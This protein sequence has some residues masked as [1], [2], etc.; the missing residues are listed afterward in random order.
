M[1][2]KWIVAKF[3]GSSVKDAAAMLRSSQI[4]ENNP[5]IKIVVISATQN[6][7][8]QL[9]FVARAAEK[10]DIETLNHVTTELV[11]KHLNIAKELFTSPKVLEELEELCGELK[12]LGSEILEEQAYTPKMMDELY[13]LGERMSSLLV[14][15]LLRLRIPNKTIN[16]LDARKIIKTSS[17]F[18]R[19]EPQI[20]LI[21]KNA[22]TDIIPYLNVDTIFVTQGF[23]GADLLGNTTTLGREGSDYSA[24]LFGEAIDAEL[25][26]IWTDV[27]GVA[28]SDPRIIENAKFIK[29]LSYDEATALATLGAK[30]LFP[31]TLLPTKRKN[32]PVFV[33]SS[34]DPSQGGTLI[35]N[36]Q[37]KGFS[38]K[39]VSQLIRPEG[40]LVSFIGT[41]LDEKENL[42]QILQKDLGENQFQFSDLTAVSISFKVTSPKMDKVESLKIAHDV[43]AKF[44]SLEF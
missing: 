31:T 41:H 35:T 39:G 29:E 37:N 14:S 32:I 44:M 8:N 4:I 24:A 5:K 34:L 33:G 15:D 16:F 12:A 20:E 2:R 3:G 7:T 36:V 42:A 38:L 19:A 1:E 18:Q 40:V 27:P 6:T 21:A 30:V 10:G 9:E 28:S 17:D 25:V 22:K 23:I 26:Q 13:S 11:N 43:L